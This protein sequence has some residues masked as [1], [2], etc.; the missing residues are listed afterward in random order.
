[1]WILGALSLV[2]VAAVLSLAIWASV[3]HRQTYPPGTR[4]QSDDDVRRRG[5]RWIGTTWGGGRG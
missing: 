2:L 5:L 4:I 3:K 1:M